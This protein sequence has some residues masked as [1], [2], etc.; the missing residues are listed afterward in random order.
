MRIIVAT[1]ACAAACLWNAR[2][3][4]C[5]IRRRLARVRLTYFDIPGLGEPI[6]L[7]LALAG[8]P[9][10]DERLTREQFQAAKPTLR[11]GQ[12]PYLTVNDHEFVQSGAILR[13]VAVAFDASGTLY[14]TANPALAASVDALMDACYDMVVG[15]KVYTYRSRFGFPDEIFTPEVTEPAFRIIWVNPPNGYSSFLH[16]VAFMCRLHSVSKPVTKTKRCR[17]TSTL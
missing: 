13:Y 6:R 9:F 14:P 5:M 2:R 4:R 11:F 8:V 10:T 7:T 16:W 1:A 17:A 12:V 15:K 3:V